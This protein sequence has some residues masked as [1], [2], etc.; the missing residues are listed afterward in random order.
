MYMELC[1]TNRIHTDAHALPTAKWKVNSRLPAPNVFRP[2]EQLQVAFLYFAAETICTA[3]RIEF[4]T[5]AFACI[6]EPFRVKPLGIR[7]VFWGVVY[8][9]Y[10]HGDQCI[11]RDSQPVAKL[12]L[13]LG[14]HVEFIAL[15]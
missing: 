13:L 1:N 14:R 2:E 8:F 7:P 6:R 5:W 4:T 11:R 10:P 15:S 12:E 3:C 9:V